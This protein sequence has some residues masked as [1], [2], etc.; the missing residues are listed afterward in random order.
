[1]SL[2]LPCKHDPS[3]PQG[4]GLSWL[5]WYPKHK[6]YH[7]GIDY[8]DGKGNADLGNPCYAVE[9]GVVE[10]V[11][12]KPSI[13]NGQNGGF[14]NHLVLYHE[15]WQRW[16]HYVHLDTVSVRKG[17]QFK[18]GEQVGTVGRSGT[19]YA[20]LHFE[21]WKPK[22][23]EVQSKHWR[24]FSWYPTGRPKHEVLELYEDPLEFIRGVDEEANENQKKYPYIGREF[25]RDQTSIQISD[26]TRMGD[27]M[28]RAEGFEML[29]RY[30][31]KFNS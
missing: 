24:A 29:R 17:Q 19:T 7:P 2:Q 30:H 12:G 6:V 27:P 10:W 9:K 25:V 5:E 4:A 8:N 11:S 13:Y 14:G 23:W 22:L 31:K 16:T 1:M 20:H 26:G 21:V 18:R 28:L 15:K 3:N